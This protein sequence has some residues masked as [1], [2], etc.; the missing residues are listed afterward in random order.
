MGFTGQTY[1]REG[2]PSLTLFVA[3]LFQLFNN[4]NREEQWG[5]FMQSFQHKNKIRILNILVFSHFCDTWLVARKE[6]KKMIKT[7][8][9]KKKGANRYY[10]TNDQLQ[11]VA[12]GSACGSRASPDS[13]INLFGTPR[14]RKISR[15]ALWC[16]PR[17]ASHWVPHTPHFLLA[18]TLKFLQRRP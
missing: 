8:F 17:Q 14:F 1:V 4:I 7:S 12:T 10:S 13:P 3:F 2:T 5:S 6:N 15:L 18:P 16:R 9:S 11:S